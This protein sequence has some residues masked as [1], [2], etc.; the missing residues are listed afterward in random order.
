[1]GLTSSGGITVNRKLQALSSSRPII[2]GPHAHDAERA[3]RRHRQPCA[4]TWLLPADGLL[5]TSERHDI[6]ITFDPSIT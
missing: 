1:M 5:L 3:V 6:K 4:A 2:S